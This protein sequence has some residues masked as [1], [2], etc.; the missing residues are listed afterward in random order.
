[1]A[2]LIMALLALLL[3]GAVPP[4]ATFTDYAGDFDRFEATTQDMPEPARLAAFHA[5]FDRLYPGL[6][7]A[8]DPAALDRRIAKALADFPALRERY[9]DTVRRFPL[10][11]DSA[12]TAFRRVFPDFVPPM[13][14]ILAHEL[15]QRDGGSDIVGGRK[16]M[17][18][19]ADVIAQIHNDDSLQPF[20]DH[21]L[22]HLEHARHFADCD[23]AWC[24]LWQ[25]GLA[26][27]AASVMTPGA[28]DHQLLLDQ[29]TLIRAPTDAHWA[30]ALCWAA[31]NF[32]V[33]DDATIGLG[34]YA[35]HHPP[36]LP[37]RFG[38]Y[39]G[40]R[41]AALAARGRGLPAIARLDDAAA[42]PV[43][44]QALA[45]LIAEAHA[46]CSAP[47]AHAPATHIAPRPA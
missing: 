6:Y 21:E 9:R 39:V 7:A 12:I 28:S 18:F 45:K 15:G 46:P 38:Y 24:P 32:D 25:E 23:Q 11:F 33:T 16:V 14:V 3:V 10:E 44:V 41:V 35:N 37:A 4:G 19:G 17:L 5:K 36:D 40:M 1:M 31:R 34:F 26:T 43:V 42:R 30:A 22:F 13:P 27:Y 47:A 2:R 8:K 20:L 29:P